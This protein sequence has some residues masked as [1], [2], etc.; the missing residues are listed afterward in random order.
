LLQLLQ[1]SLSLS[2]AQT[3]ECRD[4][5]IGV[6]A[7]LSKPCHKKGQPVW[8]NNEM[9]SV[10]VCYIG[11]NVLTVEQPYTKKGMNVIMKILE[12]DISKDSF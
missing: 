12:I 9:F 4:K 2:S 6:L 11:H 1:G 8:S 5:Q 3:D 10:I 7:R